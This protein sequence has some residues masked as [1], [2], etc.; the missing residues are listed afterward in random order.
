[1]PYT[2]PF[3][4]SGNQVGLLVYPGPVSADGFS[5]GS[6]AHYLVLPVNPDYQLTQPVR[7]SATQTIG[8]VYVDNFGLGAPTLTLTSHTGW[9]VGTGSYQHQPIDGRAA[10]D[11]LWYD[12]VLYYF[13]LLNAQSPIWPPATTM[14]FFNNIDGQFFSLMPTGQPARPRTHTKPYLYPYSLSFYV[15]LDINHQDLTNPVPTPI[16]PLV[17]LTASGSGGIQIRTTT[18]PP[19]GTPQTIHHVTVAAGDTLWGLCAQFVQGN[20]AIQAVVNAA[21]AL[22][23]LGNANM[24]Y[25]GQV[26]A[27]PVPG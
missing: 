17:D 7:T 19:G 16:D 23:H 4:Q 12:I 10:I 3:N 20:A 26:L 11:H 14:Q 18:H 5:Y 8:G 24:I 22:N 13:T 15:L 6:A 2:P 1:M 27:I 9:Q 25:P 21:V